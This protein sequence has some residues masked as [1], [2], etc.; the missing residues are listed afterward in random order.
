[1]RERERLSY[2]LYI[3]VKRKCITLDL[4]NTANFQD[5]FRYILQ[6]ERDENRE[7]ERHSEEEDIN[8]SINIK[9]STLRESSLWWST[10]LFEFSDSLQFR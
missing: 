3:E 7:R 6:A 4:V 5:S 8:K 1:V 9:K 10:L 2:I